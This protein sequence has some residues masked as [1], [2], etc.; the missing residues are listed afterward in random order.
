MDGIKAE[1]RLVTEELK[2]QILGVFEKLKKKVCMKAILNP[3]E[4]KGNEL[5]CFLTVLGGIHPLVE[6]A[7]YRP[8]E[9]PELESCLDTSM[10]PAFGL[11]LENGDF[12]G[13]AFYG[14]PGGQEVNSLIFAV[15]NAGSEGQPV[16]KRLLRK[17]EKLEKPVHFRTF[18]SL[19]CHH[20]PKM[21]IAC[22]RLCMLSPYISAD[23]VDASLYPD[24]QEKYSIERVPVTLVNLEEQVMGVKPI[25]SIVEIACDYGCSKKKK[26]F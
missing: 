7:L 22:Q 3:E 6:T 9:N 5:G 21:V 14:V 11:F 20:C 12:T 15:Y 25:E 23:M 8:G 17:L 18:V 16:E 24:I 10:L 19:A 13:A 2:A 1:S 4:E 26:F